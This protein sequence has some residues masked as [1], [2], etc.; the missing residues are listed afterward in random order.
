VTSNTLIH[1]R[2]ATAERV[3]SLRPQVV[4]AQTHISTGD[5]PT[6]I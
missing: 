2:N 3:R 4:L 5:A 1:A 6:T